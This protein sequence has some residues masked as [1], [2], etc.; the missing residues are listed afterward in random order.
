MTAKHAMKKKQKIKDKSQEEE[1]PKALRKKEVVN[2]EHIQ[3]D[4]GKVE[5][6]PNKTGNS[7]KGK[8]VKRA[9]I[10]FL[11]IAIL[12]IGICTAISNY[13]WKTL[14]KDMQVNEIS[15][16]KDSENNTIATFGSGKIK[17]TIAGTEI[18]ENLKH[19]YV[20]IEDERFYS[21]HGV[22]IKRTGAAIVSYI[23]H[24]G[25]SSFGGSTITQQLAKNLTGDNEGS[26]SRK[27]KE[28]G[29]AW[30]LESFMDKNEILDLYLNIIYV[31]P[32]I[33][34]VETGAQYYFSKSAK[35]LSLEECAF[36]AG[37]N[38]SPNSYNPFTN[39]D[40]NDKIQKRTSTVL[41]KML[42]L[43]YI[44][45][46]E[47]NQAISNVEKGLSFKKGN[48]SSNDIINSYHTDALQNQI[49]EDLS[50]QKKISTTFA[51]NYIEMAG[52]TIISTEN[53]SIQ[54]Q[55]EKEFEKSKYQLASN[56]GGK[57][58]QAAMVVIDQ[59]TGH[60]V[61]CVG[62]LGKK[63]IARGLNRATQSI[64]QTGSS[65]K[66][67]AVL[68]PGIDKKLFTGASVFS[69]VQ[70][71]FEGNYSPENYSNYLGNISVR[72]ALESSQNIPFVEMMQKVGPKTSIEYLEKMGITTLSKKDENLALALGGL[73]KGISP[74]QMAGAY[75]TIANDGVYIEPTFY[76]KTVNKNGKTILESKQKQK[77]V[78]S[79]EVAYILKELLTQPVKG[80]YGTATYCSISGIDVA[81]KTGTTDENY[82]RWLCGFTPYY[83]AVT[84]YGYDQNET[85]LYQGKKNPAGILWANIMPK[86]HSNLKNATFEKPSGVTTAIICSQSGKVANTGCPST[87]KEYFLRGT[88]P[89]KCT[90]HSGSELKENSAPKND[91]GNMNNI[92]NVIVDSF[93]MTTKDDIDE[94]PERPMNTDS[95]E[96]SN[97]NSS[98]GNS[99]SI[100]EDSSNINMDNNKNKNK[101]KNKNATSSNVTN[102][103]IS[104]DKNISSGSNLSGNS[105]TGLNNATENI[106]GGNK[107]SVNTN[108]NTNANT[109]ASSN[110]VSN[111][112]ENINNSE[113][114]NWNDYDF[115]E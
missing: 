100:N 63:T 49:I 23:F 68:A 109:S 104:T 92:K 77:R 50:K 111:K 62:G 30:T 74:L 71:N 5:F 8:K 45:E 40:I 39:T 60:V 61:G 73:D 29:N 38:N 115:F 58:S 15:T 95:N 81:A 96:D 44:N 80:S 97:V 35:D 32:N 75:A 83:T 16:V 86:I 84:W 33:Y 27:V 18:P 43:K 6:V 26:I 7:K 102:S 12:A 67:I 55:M 106:N 9:I 1:I 14:I 19:A 37:I 108:T 113:N 3:K 57:S 101:N 56:I 51:T 94:S 42:E 53:I 78:F 90:E 66:P 65:I 17:K 85:I 11:C 59:K 10:I 114:N 70:K 13:K 93:D 98:T 69:D 72:R 87:Y 79:K 22:D 88:V 24:R 91:T 82:D 48:I 2:N 28:W 47:Y 25:S 36:L 41:A 103:N 52:L 46:E 54:N 99:N 76:T 20:A 64:R 105:N 31:G 112:N 110:S 21:H 89:E 4:K 107:T 34:G